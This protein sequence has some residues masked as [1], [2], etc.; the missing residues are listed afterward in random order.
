MKQNDKNRLTIYGTMISQPVRT[1]VAFCLLHNIPYEFKVINLTK[2]EQNSEE[3]R[4]INPRSQIPAIKYIKDD[5]SDFYLDESATIVRFLSAVYKTDEK[6]YPSIEK[7]VYRRAKIDLYLDWHHLNTR[8]IL[9]NAV[10]IRVMAQIMKKSGM[11][12]KMEDTYEKIPGLFKFLNKFLEVTKYIVD[13]EMSIADIFLVNE[14]NELKL[15]N[16]DLTPYKRLNQ[17]VNEINSL[18]VM[19]TTNKDLNNMAKRVAKF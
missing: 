2:G 3:F 9:S 1:V 13:N 5:G 18:E 4:K 14:I 10:F 11:N 15:L 16:Y 12:L 8:Q 17:Y 6:W 19:E 7:D